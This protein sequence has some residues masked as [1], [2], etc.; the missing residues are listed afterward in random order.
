MTTFK[1][2]LVA[3][4]CML[5]SHASA[6]EFSSKRQ[7]V[8]LPDRWLN[9]QD[10]TQSSV[11]RPPPLKRW[12]DAQIV[13]Y[14]WGFGGTKLRNPVGFDVASEVYEQGE[15]SEFL[16]PN[17]APTLVLW[18]EK[19]IARTGQG[20][21]LWSLGLDHQ[22]FDGLEL[23][24]FTVGYGYSL[25][26]PSHRQSGFRIAGGVGG[27]VTRSSTYFDNALHGSVEAWVSVGVQFRRFVID[28]TRR[29]RKAIESTLDE[30]SAGPITRGDM[31]TFGLLF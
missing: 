16:E 15:T 11:R 23:T 13:R 29:E 4:S 9:N 6:E 27:G 19:R 7:L 2:C 30:R 24:N 31:I 22:D 21:R 18:M 26:P 12:F 20:K 1:C 28:V 14:S 3:I 5:L 8:L 25:S 17:V 10:T